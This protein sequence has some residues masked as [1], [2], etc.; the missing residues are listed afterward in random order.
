MPGQ[1]ERALLVGILTNIWRIVARCR[2][3][4]LIKDAKT[5]SMPLF[6]REKVRR[7]TV[8]D[9]VVVLGRKGTETQ[10]QDWSVIVI[11]QCQASLSFARFP[12]T[13]NLME[14][15]WRCCHKQGIPIIPYTRNGQPIIPRSD[16][17]CQVGSSTFPSQSMFSFK[18]NLVAPVFFYRAHT[19]DHATRQRPTLSGLCRIPRN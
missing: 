3:K 6:Y 19:R 14:A 15:V 16:E 2:T 4:W 7:N 9:A 17:A 5:N 8:E 13:L 12:A 10:L 11:F 18:T 1:L